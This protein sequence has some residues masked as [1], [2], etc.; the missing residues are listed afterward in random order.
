M[1]REARHMQA[2]AKEQLRRLQDMAV[3]K[4]TASEMQSLR[5]QVPSKRECDAHSVAAI[6]T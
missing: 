5:I 1:V 4:E 2:A 3:A 6:Q